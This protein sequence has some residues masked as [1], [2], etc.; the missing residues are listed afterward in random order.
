MRRIILLSVLP[1]AFILAACSSPQDIPVN[2]RTVTAEE[3][4]VVT[5]PAETPTA[6]PITRMFEPENIDTASPLCILEEPASQFILSCADN[7][8][9]IEENENRRGTDLLLTREI[10]AAISGF[11]LDAEITSQP[12]NPARLDQNQVGIFF[13]T[14]SKRK[15]AL[16]LQGQYFNFEE[17][18]I[19]NGKA[20]TIT[21]NQSYAPTMLSTGRTNNI[22]LVCLPDNCDLYANGT[23][24]GRFPLPN[25]D[26]ISSIGLFAASPW[27]ER[28]GIVTISNLSI[29]D[30]SV[31][32]PETQTFRLTDNLKADHGTFSQMGLSGA[33]SDFEADGFHFSP[34][35]PYGYYSAKAGPALR[36][37]S[38]SA[39]VEM[40]FTPGV[41]AT[42]YGG[43]M[44]RAS[45]EGMVIAVLRANATYTIYRDSERRKFAV[46]AADT[47]ENISEGRSAH[48]LRLDCIDDTISLFIDGNQVE[49]LSDTRYNIQY[50]RSGLFT[51]AGGAAYSDAIVFSDF[52]ISEIR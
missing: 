2:E 43:V 38:V 9:T 3:N 25:I 32:R 14:S 18:V 1:V 39:T 37:A 46:L 41:P 50:G 28:F 51:K 45:N 13:E 47:I 27:D 29:E 24:A 16:R 49:S 31:S 36:N 42:Q 30:L 8:I 26:G 5:M 7:Q 10:P 20:K 19:K 52:E 15:Y 21:L 22:R 4:P 40:D 44:C 6:I 34:V 12:A 33:F 35:I 17:W 11:S 48:R 23:L